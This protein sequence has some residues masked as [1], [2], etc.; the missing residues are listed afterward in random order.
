VFVHAVPDYI[1]AQEYGAGNWKAVEANRIA[2]AD[3]GI[4][5]QNV[6]LSADEPERLLSFLTADTRH[7]MIEYSLWPALQAKAKRQ[8]PHLNV[9][10]RTHNAEAYHYLHRNTRRR[11]DYAKP[12][13]WRKFGELIARDS[14]SRR[15]ADRLLGISRWD[16][17]NYWRWLPGAA[18]IEYLPY[19]SPWPFVRPQVE[20]RPWAQRRP[21]IVSMGG[22]FDPSGL[23]N[24]ANFNALAKQL[25]VISNEPW[26]FQLTW[27]SQWHQKVPAVNA[28]VE[29]LRQCDEPWDLLCD[30]RALAVLTHLGFGF[31]TT[32]VDGL[33]AGCHVIVHPRLAHRL[34]SDVANLCL[35]CD[36]SNDAHMA[37]LARTL[38]MPPAAHE[39]N[40]H[41][42]H[43]AGTALS[44]V[45]TCD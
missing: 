1:N 36:P 27:W 5:V 39:I 4:P 43:Q 12:R 23:V 26:S 13:L 32:I 19:F 34:P 6:A 25:P 38:S 28:N 22:N 17:T 45:I 24:V 11:L 44:A 15:N 9:H 37:R 14:R 16:D 8:F 33:A 18:P 40:S 7:L 30:V 20:P 21:T 10:V 31:K 29:I 41:L 35:V 42:R 3:L 2:I